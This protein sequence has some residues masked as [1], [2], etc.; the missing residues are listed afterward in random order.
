MGEDYPRTAAKGY[1]PDTDP[2]LIQLREEGLP[3]NG[4]TPF[5]D[6]AAAFAALPKEEQEQLE[7][8]YVRRKWYE[9]DAGWLA[10]IVQSNPRSGVKALHSAAWGNRLV[11]QK[12]PPYQVEGMSM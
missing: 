2:A 4:E 11:G 7:K 9:G 10:P 5:A 12:I 8:I 6:C 3:L 1:L